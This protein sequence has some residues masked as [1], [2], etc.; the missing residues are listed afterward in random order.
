MTCNCFAI[1]NITKWHN[2][3]IKSAFLCCFFKL[4]NRMRELLN[5]K[6]LPINRPGKKPSLEK[7]TDQ[8][9]SLWLQNTISFSEKMLSIF[10]MFH[11]KKAESKLKDSS[12]KG[13]SSSKSQTTFLILPGCLER[14]SFAQSQ[15]IYSSG[16]MNFELIIHSSIPCTEI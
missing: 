7:M 2:P 8:K 6:F 4:F 14:S 16:L 10:D 3:S 12:S 1:A 9:L 15:A 11:R 13:R 5:F